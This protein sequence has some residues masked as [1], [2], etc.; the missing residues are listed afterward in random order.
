MRDA[1][2]AE[3]RAWIGTPYLHQGSLRGVGADCLGLVRGVWRAVIGPEPEP[4][5][6]YTPDWAEAGGGEMLWLSALRWF[7]PC[8]DGP[9]WMAGQVILFRMRE[10]GVAKHLGIVSRIGEEA[11]FIH[12]YSG[13]G[14]IES[15]LTDPWARRMAA[16][17]E[18]PTCG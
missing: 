2:L 14:V 8:A 11:A 1:I 4:I 9:C 12:A 13:H 16:R 5:P 18:F 3:A 15:A 10:R 7:T 6:C 17:F